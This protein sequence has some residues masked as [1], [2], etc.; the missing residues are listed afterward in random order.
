MPERRSVP[1]RSSGG[2]SDGVRG[3][4][5]DPAPGAEGSRRGRRTPAGR[6]PGLRVGGAEA[7]GRRC[8]GGHGRGRDSGRG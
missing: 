2:R 6:G 4:A 8:G 5:G 1:V 7:P 3:P